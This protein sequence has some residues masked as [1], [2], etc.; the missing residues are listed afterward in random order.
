MDVTTRSMLGREL[1][2]IVR[3]PG[4]RLVSTQP[5]SVRKYNEIVEQQ[6]LMHRVPERMEAVDR[7]SRI[8]GTPT[9]PWLRSMMIKLYP[10]LP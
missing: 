7:L 5:S 3:P 10:R 1:L 4:R 9:P 6:F 8:C 2:K